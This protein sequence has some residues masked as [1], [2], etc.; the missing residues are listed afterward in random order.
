MQDGND[1]SM[2]DSA[3]LSGRLNQ[4]LKSWERGKRGKRGGAR[5]SGFNALGDDDDLGNVD[6]VTASMMAPEMLAKLP[7]AAAEEGSGTD[8]YEFVEDP[9]AA[10][11]IFSPELDPLSSVWQEGD[12]AGQTARVRPEACTY[13]LARPLISCVCCHSDQHQLQCPLRIRGRLLGHC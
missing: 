5:R 12:S 3:Q 4:M 10:A 7:G 1:E 6:T 13:F 8:E 2:F 11:S 9:A